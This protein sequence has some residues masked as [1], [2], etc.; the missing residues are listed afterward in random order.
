MAG[1]MIK[2]IL[3]AN[4]YNPKNVYVYDPDKS[5]TDQFQKDYKINISNSNEELVSSVEIIVFAV[6]PYIID[7]VITSIKD[8][9]TTDHTIISIAAG[10]KIKRI[11]S[12]FNIN[13][14]IA[15][16]M[17]NTAAQ[18]NEGMTAICYNDFMTDNEKKR[19]V[20]FIE[21]F[22]KS[23]ELEEEQF[24]MFTA[25]CGSAPAFIYLFVD[26]LAKSGSDAGIE[27]NKAIN[28]V[29]QTMVGSS[30]MIEFTKEDPLKLVE[31]VCTKGGTTIEGVNILRTLKFQEIVNKAA[32]E[33]ARRS[34]EISEE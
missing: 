14:K 29:T 2:G 30:K 31:K 12:Q 15:R 21:S 1:A 8:Y 25:I 17:S 24:D 5:K 9:V 13:V 19:S 4:L 6:K 7:N 10:I 16:I 33:T 23:V 18:I 34:K 28:I 11:E 3:N 26:A 27:F 20:D 32:V 22:G